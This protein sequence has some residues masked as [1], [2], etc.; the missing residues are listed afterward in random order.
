MSITNIKKQ[1]SSSFLYFLLLCCQFQP[2]SEHMKCIHFMWF[3]HIILKVLQCIWNVRHMCDDLQRFRAHNWVSWQ[4]S[5]TSYFV[6]NASPVSHRNFHFPSTST[7]SKLTD[8]NGIIYEAHTAAAQNGIG[9][10]V[11]GISSASQSQCLHILAC[12][13]RLPTAKLNHSISVNQCSRYELCSQ[14]DIALIT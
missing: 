9:E 2:H 1:N 10:H 14:F 5:K 13:N 3:S 12:H 7:L 4:K 11:T 8:R 6:W